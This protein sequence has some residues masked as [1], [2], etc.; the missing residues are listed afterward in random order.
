MNQRLHGAILAVINGLFTLS[1]FASPPGSWPEPRQNAQLTAAQPMAGA[2]VNA[3]I[4]VATFDSGRSQAALLHV[5]IEDSDYALFLAAG[6]LYCY[7]VD[8][9]ERWALHPEGLNFEVIS[10]IAD[11]DNDGHQEILLQAGRPTSP[12]AAA[13]LVDLE[14][15]TLRWRYEVEPMSYQWYLYVGNY[16]P[17]R[18]DQQIF[19]VMMGY[20][21][22]PKNGYCTLFAFDGKEGVPS[23]QWR[24]DFHEYTCF[25]TFYQSDLDGDGVAEL[26]IETH[27]RMWFLDAVEGTLKNFTQWDVSPANTRSYG[28]TRFVDLNGDGREDF[29]CIA[30]FSQHH[31][32]LLNRGGTLEKVWHQGW[33]ESVTTGKVVTT[34]PEPPYADVDGDGD[35]EIIVSMYNSEDEGAWLTRVYDAVDGTLQYRVPGVIATGTADLDGDGDAELMA[36]RST[37][38][39]RSRLD[40][41]VLLDV[42]DG[43]LSIRWEDSQ[44][45][46][47]ESATTVVLPDGAIRLV[48][49]GEGGTITLAAPPA[50]A[51]ASPGPDFSK[52]P[53]LVGPG[54]PMLLSGDLSGDGHQELLLYQA[55]KLTLLARDGDR[56][57]VAATYDS[58]SPPTLADF[59]GDGRLDLA[60]TNIS[61]TATPHVRVIC[62]SQGDRVVWETRF[63]ETDRAGLPQPRKAYTRTIHLT[64]KE[65]PDL[66]VWAGTPIVRSVG[67]DGMTG[68]L[69]WEKGEGVKERY[70][71]PSV[72][73]A[74]AWDFNGDGKEDLVFTNPDY[75]CVA[76]G[77]TGDLLLGPSFP[78]TIF[79]QPSQG[80]YTYPAILDRGKD[81]PEVCLVGGH[82]FQG[83]MSLTAE[84]YWYAATT[85]GENR[86]GHEA[87]LTTAEGTWLMG[88]G[89]QNGQFAC[90]DSR[91]GAV[92]WEFDVKATCSDV[93]SGDVDGDGRQEFIFGT[94]HGE[95]I[96]LGDDGAQPRVVWRI[97][98]GQAMGMPIL[99]DFDG[100][101]AVELACVQADGIIGIWDGP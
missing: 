58:T 44:A 6:T 16:L 67:L 45:R 75:Y 55:P 17:G 32:V 12:Y 10:R 101:G 78:P 49:V 29:L 11:F 21:P 80:L 100:D 95:I 56:L 87:F 25:P 8:G 41:A 74:S 68:A 54:M 31:E 36:N 48:T 85:P 22:D 76:D 96:A 42:M 62:P 73:Y 18:D 57:V 86:S 81:V 9:T 47:S 53:A 72:N 59:D 91:T 52:V 61:P 99:A 3:P 63:P 50:V 89:R 93:I 5:R 20:P 98:T 13:T 24:Y 82:Y 2:M 94:S 23:Q 35:L 71:G 84:P 90:V 4:P 34:W 79:D 46:A 97:Q 92:R 30:N 69:L 7:D 28:Y 37:D 64:G 38:P 40:G 51:P 15:G 88:Y 33:A 66:Y 83:A 70:W 19:V 1:V 60:L 26:A 65:T 77:P 14:S 43:T 39:T 27:S